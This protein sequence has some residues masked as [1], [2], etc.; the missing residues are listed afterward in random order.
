VSAL[1]LSRI[2][3]RRGERALLA[4][5]D[6]ELRDGE[7]LGIV[8]PNGAGKTTLLRVASGVLVPDAGSVSLFGRA[9][10]E[11]P[12]RER[13]R[14]IGVVP[15]D[16]ELEFGFRILEL[17][18][19]GRAPHLSGLGFESE[20]DVAVARAALAAVGIE[21]LAERSGLRVSGG[22][23]QLAF[24]A[25]AL[26]QEPKILLFDEPTSHLDLRHR[27]DV[28]RCVRD[29]SA[30]G[31]S[32]L[33]VS[34]DLALAAR[35]CDRLALLASGRLLALGS[36]QQVVEAELLERAYGIEVEVVRASD[37]TPIAVPRTAAAVGAN[38]R[39]GL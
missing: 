38:S 24:V 4:E 16:I 7:V 21:S 5:L 13:A 35:N 39:T 1:A 11:I 18:L 29:F 23:R 22:E 33:I 8:G 31:G 19:M 26:A 17:V 14:Q 3:V 32:A 6:L 2:G 12:A 10:A 15:Q 9:L 27:V 30:R 36:P 37:G 25:R 20:R 28:L 34:H